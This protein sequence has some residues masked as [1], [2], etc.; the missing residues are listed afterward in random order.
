[1]KPIER[2]AIARMPASTPG[3]RIVTSTSAQMIALIEREETMISR[4]IGRTN[5]ALGVVLRAVRKASG[6]ATA[7]ARSVPS[8]AMLIVSQS[9]FQTALI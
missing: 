5:L 2:S 6:T 3:P 9:G 1:M 8:V 4:P 7:T